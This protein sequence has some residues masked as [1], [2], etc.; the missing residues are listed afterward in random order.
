MDLHEFESVGSD[1]EWEHGNNQGSGY[2]DYY[3]NPSGKRQLHWSQQDGD[4]HGDGGGTDIGSIEYCE[5]GLWECS[6]YADSPDFALKRGMEL[7]E[8]ES[9]GGDAKRE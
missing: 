6:L 7:H 8:F 2:N 9:V 3:R 1:G 4:L 5:Q